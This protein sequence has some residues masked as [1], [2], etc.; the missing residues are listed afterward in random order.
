VKFLFRSSD[1]MCLPQALRVKAEGHQVK[2][3]VQM[4]EQ[5]DGGSG[6]IDKA[7][8]FQAALD[9]AD[10]VIY[11]VQDGPL[12]AEAERVREQKPTIGA[13][14][15]TNQLEHD[16]E[17]GIEVA[18]SAGIKVPEVE[19]FVGH[20]AFGKAN[21]YIKSFASSVNWVW[22]ANGEAPTG[23][24]TFVA[25]GGRDEMRGVL[26]HLEDLYR[27]QKKSAD[28]I[29]TTKIE[30]A[31]IGTEG[32]FNGTTFLCPNHTIERTKFFNGDLG[33]KTGCSGTS[34]WATSLESP[35]PQKLLLPLVSV[36]AGKYV[37]PID[38]NVIIEKNSNQPVFLE[39]S[40]RMGYDATFALMELIPLG[41]FSR[42]LYATA[43]GQ[44]I[45]LS[46]QSV[47]SGDVRVHIP[48]YPAKSSKDSDGE[49]VGVPIFG[50]KKSYNSHVHFVEVML[51][52][53]DELVSSG[54]H[55]NV[56][57]VTATGDT[58]EQAEERAIKLTKTITIPNMRYRLDLPEVLQKQY[59][60]VEATG[61]LGNKPQPILGLAQWKRNQTNQNRQA[62]F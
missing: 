59:N 4:P 55:G 43:T 6:L 60:E 26:K 54:P 53:E 41:E 1:G 28:F 40:P 49:S 8:N 22:K 58:V 35:L 19:E 32:W 39:F 12:Y 23:A 30:G 34:V 36:L 21:E 7:M 16:R 24:R 37:G 45:Q 57:S 9:W 46:I 2:L 33:E 61:W 38:V 31:E 15:L 29:L 56:L 11:D 5:Q 52:H 42:L 62:R 14:A 3:S 10:I 50:L 13:S 18:R 44:S 17:F 20:R 48:P 51:D 27:Q 25:N 47:F